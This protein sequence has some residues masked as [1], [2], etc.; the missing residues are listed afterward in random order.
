MSINEEADN[1]LIEGLLWENNNII[2]LAKEKVGKSIFALQMACS[3]SCGEAFLGEYEIPEAMPILYIQTEST[4]HETIQRLKAMTHEDGVSWNPD[5]FHLMCTHS[6]ELDTDHCLGWLI[7]EIEKKKLKPKVIFLDPLYMSMKGGLSDDEKSRDLSRNIRKLCEGFKCAN[8]VVHHE[9]RTRRNKEGIKID[10]GD[11]AI[12]GSFVWKAFPNH[13]IH[14]RMRADKIRTLTCTTQR[15]SRVIEEMRLHLVQPLPLHYTI[16]G[17]PDHPNYVDLV[18][19]W[20]ERHGKM[21]AVEIH[22]GTGLSLSAVKKSL[23]YLTKPNVNKLVKI[24]PGK[25][26]TYYGFRGNGKAPQ[27]A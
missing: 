14:L 3:L 18:F 12:M 19:K 4:R 16:M 6:L 9:H 8:V 17:T 1:Y 5:N 24:N 2:L 20:V 25:R 23:A 26:P 11:E 7:E 15:S 21:C 13:V 22:E 27:T 10:E